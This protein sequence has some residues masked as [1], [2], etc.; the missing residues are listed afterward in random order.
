M[1]SPIPTGAEA[2]FS[3]SYAE[4]DVRFL[5]KPVTLHPTPIAEKELMIQSGRRHYSEMIPPEEVP[6]EAYLGLY[7]AALARNGARLAG[8]VAA[9][10]AALAQRAAGRPEIVLAS[11]ARAGTPIGA[12]L[13]R[14]LQAMGVAVR[15]YSLSIIRDRGIDLEALAWIAAR[16]DPPDVVFVDGWTGKGAIAGELHRSLAGRPLGLQPY[17]A[18]IAD[19]AGRADLSATFDDYLIP[20]GILG[21]TVSGLVS[22]SILNAD[23]VG[24]GDFHACVYHAQLAPADLSRAFI[25]TVSALFAPG[26]ADPAAPAPAAAPSPAERRAAARGCDETVAAIQAMFGVS[27]RNRIKPGIAEATRA[28]LRRVPDRLL[29]RDEAELNVAHLVALAA[30]KK[31]K[32]EPLAPESPFRAIAIIRSVGTGE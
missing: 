1:P 26:R 16:H 4:E 7:R 10:A 20:S 22:R 21:S 8:D 25:D 5:L 24:P 13:L 19:P 27:D 15:H 3:G 17:L 6:D 9:L 28:L 29:V 31:V 11:L 30:A 2:G 32:I 12:L 14:A 18:V 23:L